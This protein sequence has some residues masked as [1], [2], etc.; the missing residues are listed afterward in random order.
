M[1]R[2]FPGTSPGEATTLATT[3]RRRE[4]GD[5]SDEALAA[6][7]DTVE[8]IVVDEDYRVAADTWR[9]LVHAPPGFRCVFGR[10]EP[11]LQALHRDLAEVVGMPLPG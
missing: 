1:F 10:V 4:S 8:A 11:L 3:Y 6:L 9:S 5:A 7:H 2:L